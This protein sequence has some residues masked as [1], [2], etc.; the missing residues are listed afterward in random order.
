PDT[1]VDFKLSSS[2]ATWS[3]TDSNDAVETYRTASATQALLQ[4]IRARNGYTQ[5]L[6]YNAANQVTSITDSY[7]RQLNFTY[8][9]GRLQTL[10]TPDGL[11]I[12]Y[13][14][15]GGRLTSIGYSTS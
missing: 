12:S 15:T 4:T 5:T 6:L 2:G 11:T 3:L 7:N 1:D 13:G 8:N 9:S 14:F 10:A